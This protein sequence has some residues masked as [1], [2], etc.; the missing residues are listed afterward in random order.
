MRLATVRKALTKTYGR[1]A[2]KAIARQSSRET[3]AWKSFMPRTGSFQRS[4]VSVIPRAAAH[5]LHTMISAFGF[6]N[7]SSN[8]GGGPTGTIVFRESPT[9]TS[10]ASWNS[11]IATLSPASRAVAAKMKGSEARGRVRGAPGGR[12]GVVHR[13]PLRMYLNLVSRETITSRHASARRSARTIATELGLP[14]PRPLRSSRPYRD[15][16]WS[17]CL[18]VCPS[19]SRPMSSSRLT[20]APPASCTAPHPPRANPREPR[21][22]AHLPT[23]TITLW[24]VTSSGSSRRSTEPTFDTSWPAVSP[25]SCMA[26]CGRQQISTSSCSWNRKMPDARCARSA[27]SATGHAH[28]SPRSSPRTLAFARSGFETKGLEVFSLWSR[29][30]RA[31]NRSLRSGALRL[32]PGL[33]ERAGSAA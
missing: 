18:G 5:G 29:R 11:M 7:T 21:H 17:Y 33:R 25:L 1:R 9:A 14:T 4:A 23:A 10:T 19:H 20:S 15:Q 12:Y 13:Q 27:S 3:W 16:I 31:G 6:E 28:R 30:P 8:R 2:Q 26:T 32:R 24:S 22:A